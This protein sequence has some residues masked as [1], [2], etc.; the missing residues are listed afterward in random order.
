[1][2]WLT[3]FRQA[4][5]RELPS[6]VEDGEL[7]LLRKKGYYE[8]WQEVSEAVPVCVE[9]LQ[10]FRH[11]YGGPPRERKNKQVRKPITAEEQGQRE[12]V[13]AILQVADAGQNAAVQAFRREELDGILLKP[14]EVDAWISERNTWSPPERVS[15]FDHTGVWITDAW[16]PRRERWRIQAAFEDEY[17]DIT[18]DVSELTALDGDQ[19]YFSH[20]SVPMSLE[21]IVDAQQITRHI[22]EYSIRYVASDPD[23]G[24]YFVTS[25]FV[26]TGMMERLRRLGEQLAARYGWDEADAVTFILTGDLPRVM[27]IDAEIR[28]D[29]DI[30]THSRI[31]L[32]I[33]PTLT[34][35]R[36]EVYYRQIRKQVVR[37][38]RSLQP[39][40]L[41]LIRF[42]A[43]R[44][45]GE[46]ALQRMDAWNKL[47]AKWHPKW[48]YNLES[49]FSRDC[50][51]ARQRLLH[52]P[53][54]N[55]EQPG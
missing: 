23:T 50:K 45:D 16:V 28:I 24:D 44:P 7:E 1:M 43:S 17:D 29:K 15:I 52:P 31:V 6:P 49:N 51:M 53:I 5:D 10:D 37:R 30:P 34:P 47:W 22:E 2:D 32:T 25:D 38:Y 41:E 13:L 54:Q 46:T 27:A 40:A 14:A 4:I 26:R 8:E 20:D 19:L 42:V 33:D 9:A 39:K 48:R 12:K 35:A 36:V 55:P 11:T 21:V 3:R 18:E